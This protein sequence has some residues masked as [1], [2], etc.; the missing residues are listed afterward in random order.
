MIIHTMCVYES[1]DSDESAHMC[2]LSFYLL[3]ASETGI[4]FICADRIHINSEIAPRNL[5]I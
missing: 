5:Y 1:E 2:N 3:V 4:I